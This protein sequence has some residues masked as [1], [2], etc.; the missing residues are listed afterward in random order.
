MG[1]KA[2]ATLVAGGGPPVGGSGTPNTVPK[3]DTTT[4]LND[5]VITQSG[6]NVGINKTIPLYPIDVV[7]AGGAVIKVTRDTLNGFDA[8]ITTVM[9]GTGAGDLAWGTTQVDGGFAWRVNNSATFA[10]GITETGNVGIGNAG[11][12]YDV[13]LIKTTVGGVVSRIR[14]SS[15]DATAEAVLVLNASG[16]AWGLAMGSA[17][18]NSNA[19]TWVI[20]YGGAN[21]ERMRLTP[22]GNVGIG[23]TSPAC[24]LDVNGTIKTS[25]YT[26]GTLP[27][28]T[29]GQ[30]AYV[31]DATLP[32]YLGALVGG[33]AVYAPVFHNGTTWVSA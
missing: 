26:V 16:N 4:T 22:A 32:T 24:A 18:K 3:W 33:G 25:G 21:T 28:G 27:A 1:L 10:M 12:A 6:S 30:R 23:T 13:D 17:A 8:V 15:T 7:S 9:T 20:D 11:P 31:T 29:A 5:S 14:N 2:V 19:L